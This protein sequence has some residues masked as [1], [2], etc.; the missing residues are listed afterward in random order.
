MCVAVALVRGLAQYQIQQIGNFWVDLV[1]S[2]VRILVPLSSSSSWFCWCSGWSRTSMAHK[3][4]RP[5]PVATRRSLVARLPRGK[6][7]KLMSGD[8]GGAFNV[9]SAHPFENPTPA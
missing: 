9:N 4:F 3:R 6:P 8:G 2:V 1:R 7:I 5:W